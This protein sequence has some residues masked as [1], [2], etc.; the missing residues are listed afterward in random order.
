MNRAPA[1]VL[2]Q[3]LLVCNGCRGSGDPQP[4]SEEPTTSETTG[5][6]TGV[7]T[8]TGTATGTPTG[9]PTGTTTGT[10]TGTTTP[11]PGPGEV[12]LATADALVSGGDCFA[13]GDATGDGVEDL[14]CNDVAAIHVVPGPFA[15]GATVDVTDGFT[16][17]GVS[18]GRKVGDLDGDGHA[19]LGLRVTLPY[20]YTAGLLYGPFLA[21]RVVTAPD[22]TWE[23]EPLFYGQRADFAFVGDLDGDGVDEAAVVEEHLGL[24][25]ATDP[26]PSQARWI[27]GSVSILGV[28]DVA[29]GGDLDSDGIADLVYEV[30]GQ[31][32]YVQE[33]ALGA[34]VGIAG[35]F[36]SV[37]H[38]T[39]YPV[40]ARNVGDADGDGADDLITFVAN[41]THDGTI[42]LFRGPLAGPYVPTDAVLTLTDA[43]SGVGFADPQLSPHPVPVGDTDGDGVPELAIPTPDLDHGRVWLV[44]LDLTGAVEVET[45]FQAAYFS[46]FDS[47]TTA[48][49]LDA[50]DDGDDD[51]GITGAVVG[52]YP[53]TWLFF[54]P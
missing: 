32:I 20:S 29:P 19:D 46:P 44:P 12:H 9:T 13:M 30:Q 1:V 45:V 11:A 3:A 50:D 22:V 8:T 5:T 26:L 40:G 37:D 47:A 10:A 41:G 25:L 7:G 35:G 15:A 28:T 53:Q 33:P 24:V 14:A 42:T 54:G 51:L 6:T 18:G 31:A 36:A 43:S 17:T 48:L 21:D 34:G 49:A 4:R 16:L 38:G 39:N 27:D 23:L 52:T 2:L